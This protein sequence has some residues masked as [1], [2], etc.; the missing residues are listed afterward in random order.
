LLSFDTTKLVS[1]PDHARLGMT[2]VGTAPVPVAVVND[3]RSVIVGNSNR[4]DADQSKQQMLDVLR[5]ADLTVSAH[6][7]AGSFPR[8]MRLSPD[9]NT[10][11]LTNFS[12]DSLQIIDLKR[13]VP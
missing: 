10:L 2:Q 5:A 12:S 13:S 4:F 11:F 1:N 6:I 3:G 7:P 8:E 9:G